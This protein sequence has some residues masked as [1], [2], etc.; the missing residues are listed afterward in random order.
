MLKYNTI[1]IFFL[2]YKEAK[3]LVKSKKVFGSKLKPHKKI[4]RYRVK[5]SDIAHF[6]SHV[7]QKNT[8]V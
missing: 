7:L 6:T 8:R 3:K 1:N 4:V 2:R 5:E